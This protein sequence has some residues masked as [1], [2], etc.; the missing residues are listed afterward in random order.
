VKHI[1]LLILLFF[2]T[3]S[4]GQLKFS[5][6]RNVIAQ[7]TT[8]I[9]LKE[10]DNKKELSVVSEVERFGEPDFTSIRGREIFRIVMHGAPA[11]T[12]DIRIQT[13]ERRDSL[14]I[15]TLKY[16]KNLRKKQI[17]VHS[18]TYDITKWN[19]FMSLAGK[20]FI[21]EVETSESKRTLGDE[22]FELYEFNQNGAYKMMYGSDAPTG[23]LTL[24]EYLDYLTSPI[25]NDECP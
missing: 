15:V 10:R 14:C 13:I 1:P 17:L 9:L 4:L 2:S 3:A 22:S 5:F 6:E 21:R 25:F 16:V 23:I 7:S 8:C 24:M 12:K 11:N 20:Y 19:E 18:K